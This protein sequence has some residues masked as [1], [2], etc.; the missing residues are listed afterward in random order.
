MGVV[1]GIARAGSKVGTALVISTGSVPFTFAGGAKFSTGTP[2]S[3]FFIYAFQ[4]MAGKVP[5]VTDGRPPM[6]LSES[7]AS[8]LNIATLV[9]N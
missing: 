6:P 1:V 3:A 5:P 2:L 9:A 7:V 4:I 8:V